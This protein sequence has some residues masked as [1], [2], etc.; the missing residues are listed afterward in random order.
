MWWC[1]GHNVGTDNRN[2]AQNITHANGLKR[3]EVDELGAVAGPLVVHE[4][5]DALVLPV[6]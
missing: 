4:H 1:S 3:T 5:V 6:P 2:T